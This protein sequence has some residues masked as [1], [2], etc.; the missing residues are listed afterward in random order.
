MSGKQYI[1]TERQLQKLKDLLEKFTEY[2]HYFPDETRALGWVIEDIEEQ[3]LTF[4]STIE[5]LAQE[6]A[7]KA[8]SEVR[9]KATPEL[10]EKE[11]TMPAYAFRLCNY[12]RTIATATTFFPHLQYINCFELWNKAVKAEEKEAGAAYDVFMKALESKDA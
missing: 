3:E 2:S 8:Y 6:L 11:L 4:R 1:V 10:N 7:K 5:K 12:Y 9:T